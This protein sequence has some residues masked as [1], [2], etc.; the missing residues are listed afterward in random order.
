M[1]LSE[2]FSIVR[3]I[4]MPSH[5]CVTVL[6][7]NKKALRFSETSGIT[8]PTRMSYPRR[9]V[10]GSSDVTK[11]VASSV[12]FEFIFMCLDANLSYY[13]Y[14]NRTCCGT[15]R[16]RTTMKHAT[17]RRNVNFNSVLQMQSLLFC[18]PDWP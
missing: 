14:Y 9:P 11:N 18:L 8:H 5:L 10:T 6:E 4:L 12:H 16:T 7:L 1:P 13:M 2:W 3:R 17:R 15:A